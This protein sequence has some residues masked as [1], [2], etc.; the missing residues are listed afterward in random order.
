MLSLRRV[1]QSKALAS[2]FGGRMVHSPSRSHFTPAY[3]DDLEGLYKYTRGRWFC[4][5]RERELPVY[6]VIS[7]YLRRF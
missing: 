4:N 1:F 5:E 6:A 2:A 3:L 7:Y